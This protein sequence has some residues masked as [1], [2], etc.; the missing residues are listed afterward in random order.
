VTCKTYLKRLNVTQ[1]MSDHMLPCMEGSLRSSSHRPASAR[2]PGTADSDGGAGQESDTDAD[3]RP[4]RSSGGGRARGRQA[5]QAKSYEMLF[6]CQ[7]KLVDPTGHAWPV[8]YEGVLCAGQR[9]LR[10]TC[11]W[12]EFIKARKIGIGD[13][14]TFE[15]CARSAVTEPASRCNRAS[16]DAPPLLL[17]R[18]AYT[19]LTRCAA[20]DCLVCLLCLQARQQP[21]GPGSV[22]EAGRQRN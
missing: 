11:G 19:V 13:A 17:P 12:S 1:F 2:Q 20:D 5:G 22:C 18:G 10:L 4:A 16:C 14:V 15:R 21:C 7:V 8:M 3:Q 6:K 9:H